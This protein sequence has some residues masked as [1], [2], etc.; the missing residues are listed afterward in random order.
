MD[1]TVVSFNIGSNDLGQ[2]M[3]IVINLEAAV[4]INIA[5]LNR[6]D[7][8]ANRYIGGQHLGTE[9]VVEQHVSQQLRVLEQIFLRDVQF[10][11][12]VSKRGIGWCKDGKRSFA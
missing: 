1:H 4:D 11:Q 5:A 8:R 6:G 10:G 7:V 12:Q 9:H 3:T 2:A